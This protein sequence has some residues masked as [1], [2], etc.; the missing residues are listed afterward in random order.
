MTKIE[1]KEPYVFAQWC[2]KFGW[3]PE[4]VS[5]NTYWINS[6]SRLTLSQLQQVFKD[7]KEAHNELVKPDITQEEV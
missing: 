6:K 5:A 7:W 2:E 3:K 1:T 4:K